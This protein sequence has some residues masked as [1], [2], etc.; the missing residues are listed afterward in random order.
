[1]REQVAGDR[2]ASRLRLTGK[3]RES[4]TAQAQAH[5]LWIGEM[6]DHLSPEDAA[7]IAALLNRASTIRE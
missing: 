4:F 1:M 7:R 6:L 3:G 5:K 2:R